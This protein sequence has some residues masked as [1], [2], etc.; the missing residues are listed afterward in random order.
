MFDEINPNTVHLPLPKALATKSAEIAVKIRATPKIADIEARAIA[1][2]TKL[3]QL[4]Q[5]A[6]DTHDTLPNI[7]RRYRLSNTL[8]NYF[9]DTVWSKMRS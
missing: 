6:V 8:Q 4:C 2:F 5:T 7:T 9:E 1:K 3:T